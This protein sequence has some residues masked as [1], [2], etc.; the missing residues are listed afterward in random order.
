M[1]TLIEVY[2]SYGCIGR[3]DA[4]CYDAKEPECKCICGGVNHGVGLKRAIE[5]SRELVDGDILKDVAP[6]HPGD[7][8]YVKRRGFQMKLFDDGGPTGADGKVC[9]MRS[10]VAVAK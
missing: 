5:F 8:P 6:S 3:C 9:K 10:R 4:R 2:N 7:E 1:A